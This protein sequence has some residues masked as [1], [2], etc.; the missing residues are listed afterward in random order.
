M[1]FDAVKRSE[2]EAAKLSDCPV[3]TD[4]QVG[5]AIFKTE[6]V[7]GESVKLFK[8]TGLIVCFCRAYGWSQEDIE[9]YAIVRDHEHKSWVLTKLV[10]D[11]GHS[12]SRRR[13]GVDYINPEQLPLDEI[14]EEVEPYYDPFFYEE[15]E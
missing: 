8:F 7:D 1:R 3:L 13:R 9:E 11:L 12:S 6:V 14:P 5:E 15:E 2:L 4:E 10:M